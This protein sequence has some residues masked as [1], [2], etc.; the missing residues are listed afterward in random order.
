MGEATVRIVRQVRQVRQVRV[1]RVVRQFLLQHGKQAKYLIYIHMGAIGESIGNC[2]T[3]LTR[4]RALF[5]ADLVP[6]PP[7]LDGP[8]TGGMTFLSTHTG[9]LADG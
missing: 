4:S 9:G 8:E 6:M 7:F 5:T 1:V 2:L 3:C